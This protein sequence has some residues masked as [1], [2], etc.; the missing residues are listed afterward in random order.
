MS[1]FRDTLLTLLGRLTTG[2]GGLALMMTLIDI[3]YGVVTRYLVGQAPIWSDELARY[4]LIA[5]ALLIAGN[6]WV[7]GEHMRVALLERH[8][9]ATARR[10]LLAYQWLLTLGLALAMTWWSWHYALSVS[11]FTS[12]G[13]GISRTIPMLAMPIGFGL[14]ALQVLIYGP[15]P[16]PQPGIDDADTVSEASS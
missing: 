15:R 5:S 1:M 11:Y 16:L 2:L 10:V 14:L 3:L 4:C 13:L 12:Q 7:R 6:V 8:L 9:G